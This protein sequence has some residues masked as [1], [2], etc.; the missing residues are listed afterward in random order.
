MVFRGRW[1]ILAELCRGYWEHR[2]VTITSMDIPVGSIGWVLGEIISFCTWANRFKVVPYNT[3][4]EKTPL[5]VDGSFEN[6]PW[7]SLPPPLK[8]LRNL[9]RGRTSTYNFYHFSHCGLSLEEFLPCRKGSDQWKL[10]LFGDP[11][12]DISKY[13]LTFNLK[14]VEYSSITYYGW[15]PEIADFPLQDGK[16]EFVW[17]RVRRG[18]TFFQMDAWPKGNPRHMN[19]AWTPKRGTNRSGLQFEATWVFPRIGVGPQNGWFIMEN[20]LKMD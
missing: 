20:P 10:A 9:L 13:F 8:K 2:P 14:S 15:F 12:G 7:K 19:L 11:N 1:L 4:P 3:E 16:W 5:R 18:Q 17:S 6:A